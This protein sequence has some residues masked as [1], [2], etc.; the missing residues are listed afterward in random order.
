MSLRETITAAVKSAMLA[1]DAERTS[2]LRMIQAKLKDT[3]IA[4]RPKGVEAV[5]DEEIFAM[6]R[7]MIKS[8]RDSVTLYRQ[9]GREELAA[10]EE[11]E[12]AVI[13]EFLPHTLSGGA[14]Q[15]AITEAVAASGA[16]GA[17]DM[18]KVI[19]A[20][21]AKHGAALDMAVAS[22]AVKAALGA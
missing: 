22:A 5:P 12:I 17:K 6:L 21:K 14:L 8:R 13:E 10:K 19:G 16:T 11:A 7:S 3:D 1:R 4:A 2:A 20:L 9:G 15:A 18:G